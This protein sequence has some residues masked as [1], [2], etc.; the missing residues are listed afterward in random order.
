MKG[1]VKIVLV[2]SD[3]LEFVNRVL[4]IRPGFELLAFCTHQ[5]LCILFWSKN[6]LLLPFPLWIRCVFLDRSRS[7]S[8][9][10]GP[11][12]GLFETSYPFLDAF[13]AVLSMKGQDPLPFLISL[14]HQV[15]VFLLQLT[16][17]FPLHDTRAILI[18]TI[19]QGWHSDP[20]RIRRRAYCTERGKNSPKNRWQPQVSSAKGCMGREWVAIGNKEAEHP[21]SS[22][23]RVAVVWDIT[24]PSNSF[25]LGTTRHTRY[26]LPEGS[27]LLLWEQLPEGGLALPIAFHHTSTGLSARRGA[28]QDTV[29]SR[30]AF[31]L[32]FMLCLP[33]RLGGAAVSS[34]LHPPCLLPASSAFTDT[35]QVLLAPPQRTNWPPLTV[36]FA[37]HGVATHCSSEIFVFIASF[38]KKTTGNWAVHG[39]LWPFF[40]QRCS[41]TALPKHISLLS[42]RM[43]P[44]ASAPITASSSPEAGNPL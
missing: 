39:D 18:N 43:S 35:G 2:V 16:H 3:W 25:P 44:Y 30:R 41:H 19:I 9:A 5:S 17:S 10:M 24:L 13:Q 14:H 7:D 34:G 27:A 32:C 38:K 26:R 8:F 29:G 6:S 36:L 15:L 33:G 11:I 31:C 40:P 4:Q 42:F 23:R 22:L 20:G 28:S 37:Q 21:S 1:M 12:P